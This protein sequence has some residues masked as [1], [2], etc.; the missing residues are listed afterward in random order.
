MQCCVELFGQHCIG[1]LPAQ[2]YPRSTKTTLDRIFSDAMLSGASWAILHRVFSCPDVV[3][4][5]LRQ[6][7]ARLFLTHG[8]L[9]LFGQHCIEFWH[10]QCCPKSIKVKLYRTFFYAMLSGASRSTLHR[11]FTYTMLSQEY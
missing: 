6:H 3:P 1:F 8:C 7:C 11:T 9:D 5:V 10:V 2:C 4:T